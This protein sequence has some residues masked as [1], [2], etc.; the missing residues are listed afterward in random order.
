MQLDQEVEE[1][2]DVVR[3]GPCWLVSVVF[4][5]CHFG[6]C[7]GLARQEIGQTA[8]IS[9]SHFVHDGEGGGEEGSFLS[10]VALKSLC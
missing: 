8:H 6:N 2:K 4:Q 7:L 5:G 1:L 9:L 10:V 3:I